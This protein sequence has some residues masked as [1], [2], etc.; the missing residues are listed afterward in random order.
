MRRRASKSTWMTDGIG[1]AR[2]RP[3]AWSRAPGCPG[4]RRWSRRARER[5]I[6]VIGE[7]ELGLAAAPER[8]RRGDRHERQDDDDRAARAHLPRR[9]ASRSRWPATSARRSPRWSARSTAEATVVCECSSFQL[10][11]TDRLRAR[12]APCFLNLAPDHLD[13][14]GDARRLPRREAADLRQPGQRRRRRLQRRRAGA[15]AASTSAAAPAGSRFWP[16][17]PAPDCELALADG[18]IFGG[19]TSR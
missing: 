3:H 19:A 15:R 18:A 16:T 2:A 14:H 12:G 7:L 6:E 5:A 13:R 1:A 4:R 9:P 17:A 10:E 11:D 8:V